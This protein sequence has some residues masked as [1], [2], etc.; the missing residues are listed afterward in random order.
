VVILFVFGHDYCHKS[1]HN[2]TPT[3]FFFHFAFFSNRVGSGLTRC[4]PTPPGIRLTYQG[5]F[6]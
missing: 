6:Y 2:V 1:Y 4:P 3:G 5:G